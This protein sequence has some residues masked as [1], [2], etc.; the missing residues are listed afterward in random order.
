[1]FEY[2][3]PKVEHGRT[4]QAKTLRH[5]TEDVTP[6]L[7][8]CIQVHYQEVWKTLVRQSKN[9]AAASGLLFEQCVYDA[10]C[11]SGVDPAWITTGVDLADGNNAEADFLISPPGTHSR[12]VFAKVSLRERWKQIDRDAIVIGY[13]NK[14][15]QDHMSLIFLAEHQGDT[16]AQATRKAAVTEAQ[17]YSRARVITAIHHESVRLW[18]ETLT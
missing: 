5:L 2:I 12:V 18:L 9:P 16:I 11:Q 6:D 3:H 10:M 17:L 13:T 14:K 15:L 1:M 4:F 7:G 8:A